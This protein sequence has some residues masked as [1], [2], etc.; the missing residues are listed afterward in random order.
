[1][2]LR[3]RLRQLLVQSIPRGDT[4]ERVTKSALWLAGQNATGRVIQ[5]AMMVAL[6]R[7]IGPA[8]LGLVSIALLAVEGFQRLTNIGLNSALIQKDEEDVDDDL[9]TVWVLELGRGAAMMLALFALAPLIASVFN[10]PRA[11]DLLRV[12][13]LSPFL[14]GLRNPG[15]VY[16]SKD[17]EFHKQFVYRITSEVGQFAVAVGL[18]LVYPTAWAFAA[19]YLTADVIRVTA[20]Y[21]IDSYRPSLSFDRETAMELIDYGKWLTGSSILY[22]IYDKGDD[23]FVGWFLS[24]TVLAF[25]QYAYRFSNAPATEISGV[26]TGVMFPALSKL[27]SDPIAL[28]NA[29]LKSVRL[30]SFVTF[31]SAVGI[32]VVTP[33]FVRGFLGSEWTPMILPMQLLCGYGLLRSLGRTF[34]P[35]W[36]AIGRPDITT[37]MSVVNVTLLATLIYPVTA[38]WGIVGTAALVVGINLFVL[39]PIDLAIIVR[40]VETDY[41]TL[42]SQFVYPLVASVVMAV[43]TWS[44]HLALDVSP[45]VEFALLVP[46]G[47]VLY[48]AVA[49]ALE[50]QFRWGIGD[51]LRTIVS[52]VRS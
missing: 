24:P 47:I 7:L 25:Y 34:G 36:K 41:L 40:T 27:Q 13:S 12:V 33:S 45:L 19:G 5:L 50:S 49:G 23:A 42:V 28:R 2:T 4:A 15:M 43:G 32:A 11:T 29:F 21:L 52:Q 31:P 6:A 46:A 48:V 18:A 17:L 10:E 35:V 38:R 14:L 37:K 8:E 3:D 30:T 51:D 26:I 39:M 20:S 16:F 44:L 22:F 1:M 9:D